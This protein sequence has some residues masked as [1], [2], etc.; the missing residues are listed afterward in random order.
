[1][2]QFVSDVINIWKGPE[3]DE[4]PITIDIDEMEKMIE[5]IKKTWDI[6]DGSYNPD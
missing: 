4:S 2:V 1:M 5:I 3:A 6:N